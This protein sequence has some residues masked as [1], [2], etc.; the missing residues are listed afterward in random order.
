MQGHTICDFSQ[1]LIPR[2][3]HK[4]TTSPTPPNFPNVD[5]DSN[6]IDAC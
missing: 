4:A 6:C 1:V 5:D 3:A 2:G